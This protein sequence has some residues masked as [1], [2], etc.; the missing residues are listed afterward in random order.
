MQLLFHNDSES[1]AFLSWYFNFFLQM[2]Q[3]TYQSDS[4][5]H[6]ILQLDQ[7]IQNVELERKRE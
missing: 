4:C 6:I 2:V 1:W 5:V 7:E 3:T